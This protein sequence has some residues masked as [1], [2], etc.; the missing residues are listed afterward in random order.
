[1][2]VDEDLMKW[3]AEENIDLK[4]APVF[5]YIYEFRPVK[6]T[7]RGLGVCTVC[8][9]SIIRL[10]LSI[11]DQVVHKTPPSS[12]LPTHR[13]LSAILQ[14]TIPWGDQPIDG[15]VS[16]FASRWPGSRQ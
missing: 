2:G 12:S 5:Y 9:Q 4:V 16:V 1:M 13:I 15:S 7:N 8:R 14:S 11:R 10:L 3:I 6:R